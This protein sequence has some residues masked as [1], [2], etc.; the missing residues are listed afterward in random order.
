MPLSEKREELLVKRTLMLKNQELLDFEVDTDKREIRILDAPEM[1]D[2]LLRS[3]GFGGP[4]RE[5]FLSKILG[6]RHISAGRVDL[7]QIL[8]AFGVKSAFELSFMGH[9]MSFID[10]LWYRAP[11]ATERWED[12]NFYDNDWDSTYRT[13]ILTRDYK[14]LANCSPDIPDVT[15]SGFLRKAWERADEGVQL[16]KEPLFESG[17]DTEGAL[18]GV[19]L[20]RLLYGQD[21][22][23]PL[24]VVERF[25]KRFEA[26]PLMVGRDEELVQGY[27]LFA[28]GGYDMR[29]SSELMGPVSPESYI[30]IISHAGVTDALTH[31]AKEFAFTDLS[32]LAD[33]H[34]GNYGLFRNIETGQHRVAPP[35]DYDRAF[36]FPGEEF[37]I[38]SIC[39]KPEVA[40][41]L[42]ASTFSHLDSSWDWSWYDPKALEGFEQKIIEGHARC[43]D[44]SPRLGNVVANLFSMQR[45]YLNNIVSKWQQMV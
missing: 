12:I 33:V 13:A 2:E 3:L 14:S 36:G 18:L 19:E 28:M 35:F 37:P 30:D 4:E 40:A 22:Y 1:D 29:A 16:L 6:A 11:G 20:C 9:G 26:S 10:K 24:Y 44:T 38:E 45:D 23:Q 41:F 17:C 15:T 34:T 31:V 5:A 43:I 21:E 27:R 39:E 32:L 7:N 25:G 8:E 42:C